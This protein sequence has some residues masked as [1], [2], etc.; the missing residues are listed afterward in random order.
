MLAGQG[1]TARLI[2][3]LHAH[4][5]KYNNI[6]GQRLQMIVCSATLHNMAVQKLAV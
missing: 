6:T 3:E 2:Q 5:P 1:D 4:I